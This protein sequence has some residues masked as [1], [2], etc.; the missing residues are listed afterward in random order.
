[1]GTLIGWLLAGIAVLAICHIG[2]SNGEHT[3]I[4][5]PKCRSPLDD[6]SLLGDNNGVRIYVCTRCDFRSD[7]DCSLTRTPVRL[8]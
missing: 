2:A 8:G 6:A 5:C 3:T 1:M 7:W 4:R